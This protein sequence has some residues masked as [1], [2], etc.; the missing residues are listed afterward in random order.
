MNETSLNATSFRKLP[1]LCSPRPPPPTP[2]HWRARFTLAGISA[3]AHR[4]GFRGRQPWPRPP[5]PLQLQLSPFPVLALRS[6]FHQHL[7]RCL[8]SA[9][10]GST[11]KFLFFFPKTFYP[12]FLYSYF[13]IFCVGLIYHAGTR[14][15]KMF[16]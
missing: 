12:R 10:L 15:P 1:T 11:A 9:K 7:E 13:C 5:G 14:N 16:P 2:I 6:V 8:S 3:L 4:L